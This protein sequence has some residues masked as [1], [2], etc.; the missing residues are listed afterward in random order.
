M[1]HHLKVGNKGIAVPQA[2][3]RAGVGLLLFAAVNKKVHSRKLSLHHDAQKSARSQ[4]DT[5]LRPKAASPKH[6]TRPQ[7]KQC[8]S[9]NL[10]FGTPQRHT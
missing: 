9:A 1:S 6:S 5:L 3:P 7:Q 10:E 8:F 4:I 2:A